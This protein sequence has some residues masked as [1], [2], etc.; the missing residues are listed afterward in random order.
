MRSTLHYPRR[1]AGIAVLSVI[2]LTPG[3]SAFATEPVQGKEGEAIDWLVPVGFVIINSTTS[4][5]DAI[6]F[7]H[8]ASAKC[9]IPINLRG[10]V[11]DP[12]HGLTLSR[13]RFTATEPSEYPWYFPRGRGDDGEYI[14]VEWSGAYPEFRP[15]LFV[16][17]AASGEPKS[18][19]LNQTL[20][21]V[22]LTY[23][24]AYVKVAKIYYGCMH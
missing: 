18:A 23:R 17:I 1:L 8:A 16:V 2:L 21:K 24:R 5:D 3:S 22:K 4:Y 9:S 15:G 12:D 7:A 10:L 20:A 19:L 14:S 11:L 13:D 6:R